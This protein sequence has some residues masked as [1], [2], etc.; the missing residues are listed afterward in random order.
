M[1]EPLP[2]N[3]CA[4]EI[5]QKFTFCVVL[6]NTKPEF[7][8]FLDW[9]TVIGLVV[10]AG[11]LWRLTRDMREFEIRVTNEMREIRTEMH[12]L[13]KRVAKIERSLF[14]PPPGRERQG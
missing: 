1:S 11:F 9:G 6:G 2:N 14:H 4:G 8:N 3:G 7:L 5:Q 13:G 10:I 12:T